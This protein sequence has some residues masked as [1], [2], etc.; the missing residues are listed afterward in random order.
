MG[1]LHLENVSK[2]YKNHAAV[3]KVNFT[4]NRGEFAT[5]VGPSG[6]GKTT[7]L[8]MIAGFIEPTEGNITLDGD[9]LV[10]TA[11][12]KFLPPERR[13]IGMVFQS[14]AVWPH[15]NVFDNVAYPL[16]FRKLSK[17]DIRQKTLEILQAVHLGDFEKRFPHELSGGQQQRVA[18]ARALVMEPRLLLLDEPLSNLDAALRE[19]MRIEIKEIQRKMGV[20]IINVTHDQVEALTMSDKMIVM[21]KGDVV[22]I[23][24]PQEIYNQPAN[25]FVARFIGSANVIPATHVGGNKA[26]VM[27]VKILDVHVEVPRRKTDQ[28]TGLLAVRP[29]HIRPDEKSQLRGQIVGKLY[30][31]DRVE[32]I[33][34]VKDEKITFFVNA[35]EGYDF[36]LDDEVGIAFTHA[37]WLDN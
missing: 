16:K 11:G 24:T 20:T 29:Q 33:L 32:Y 22:Q 37:V 30:Q 5:I 17:S 8:R 15:M 13:G 35:N 27:T 6:C 12:K 28:L 9:Q 3:N 18:L 36:N 25:S 19:Q 26:D 7:T 10:D 31:G 4:I 14:Y 1:T 23:G 21:N 2:I 34:R